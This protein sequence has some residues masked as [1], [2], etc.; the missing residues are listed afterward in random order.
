MR[1][2]EKND[3]NIVDIILDN[4]GYELFTDFC[5]AAFLI[6]IKFADKVRLYPKLYPWY[7]SDATIND[8]HWTIEY[9]KNA[10]NECLKKFAILIETYLNNN[11]WT[12]EVIFNK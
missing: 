9:M 2:P 12:I 10:T 8:I 1:K 6:A 3:I 7:I 5:L 11:I 4:A